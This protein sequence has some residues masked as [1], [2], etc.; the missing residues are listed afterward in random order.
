MEKNGS[1]GPDSRKTGGGYKDNVSDNKK[2]PKLALA[3]NKPAPPDWIVEGQGEPLRPMAA[4]GVGR[5]RHGATVRN[6]AAT[7]A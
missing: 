2:A 4:P 3:G 7:W 1:G 5:R 6:P